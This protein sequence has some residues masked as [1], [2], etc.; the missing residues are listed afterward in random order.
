MRGA[1]S[2]ALKRNVSNELS[3]ANQDF[4]EFYVNGRRWRI[5]RPDPHALLLDWLRSPEV[6]LTG[7]KKGCGQGGCG[8]C[9]VMLSRWEPATG[10]VVHESINSCLRPLC[11]VDG[12]AVTTTEGTGNVATGLNPVQH[13]IAIDNGSQCGYCTPGW[14]MTMTAYLAANPGRKP[15]QLEIEQLFDGNLCRCTGYRPILYAMRHF[16]SDWTPADEQGSMTCIANPEAPIAPGIIAPEPPARRGGALEIAGE[17]STWYRPASLAELLELLGRLDPKATKL[18]NGNSSIGIYDRYDEHPAQ[19]VDISRLKELRQFK[20]SRTHLQFGA[21]GS[22]ADLLAFFAALPKEAGDNPAVAAMGY[23]AERTAGHIVRN[24]A[25]L[26]GNT[27][28]V[29]RHV[30][31]GVPFPS[32]LFTALCACSAEV[33]FALPGYAEHHR[34]PIHD[35]AAQWEEKPTLQRAVLVAYHVPLADKREYV[36]TYKVALREVNAHAIVNAGMRV[37]FDAAGKVEDCAVVL[38]GIGPIAFHAR[39]TQQAMVGQVWST[40]TL[41]AALKALRADLDAELK[42]WAKR[43]ADLPDEGFTDSYRRHLAESFLYKFFVEVAEATKAFPVPAPVAGAGQRYLRPL[44][45]GKQF[46][47][48]N[49]DPAPVGLPIVK[50]DAFLQ[51][52]GEAQY[53]HD[54]PLPPRGLEAALVLSDRAVGGFFFQLPDQ[55]GKPV[56]ADVLSDWLVGHY[57]GVERLVTAA[58]VP[59]KQNNRSAGVAD[60]VGGIDPLFAEQSV[61]WYGQPLGVLLAKTELQ[62]ID[63]A[64]FVRTRCVGYPHTPEPLLTIAAARASGSV[65]ADTPV[66]AYNHI[67]AIERPKSELGWKGSSKPVRLDGSECLVINGRQ[68]VGSQAHFY[69]ETQSIVAVP[70]EWGRMQLFPSTQSPD[71]VQTFAAD[72]LGTALGKIDVSVKRVGGG[73]GGKTTRPPFLAAPVALAAKVTGRPVRLAARREEDM[74]A[75]GR[76]HAYEGSY[77]LAVST[78]VGRADKGRILGADMT[79]WAN[80]GA[81]YDCSFVV[82]DCLQMRVD[83]AYMVPNWRTEGHVARTNLATSTAFRSM[84]LIQGVI[85]FEDAIAAAA[86]ALGMRAEDL[87][88]VNLYQP[89]DETVVGTV[90]DICY[91]RQVWKYLR[92]KADFDARAAA[93]D[94]FNQANR[95]RKRGIAMIPVQYGAGYN[96]AFLEQAG[97]LVEVYE[98]DA[99]LLIHQGGVELGQG[100]AVKVAQVAAQ[101][102][103]VPLELITIADTDL[104]VVPN[105]VSTGA[106]TGTGFNAEAVRTACIDLSDRLKAYVESLRK[107]NGDAWCTKNNI[108][109]WNYP[110]GWRAAPGGKSIWATIVGKAHFDRVNLSSQVRVAIPGGD[111]P[112][113][114]LQFSSPETAEQGVD[115]FTGYTFSA[116]CAEVE[117]DVLTGETTVLRA[118]LCYDI[119]DSLNPA[120]DIGQ[121]EG[122]FVQGLGYVLT[123]ELVTQQTGPRAGR[124][125]SNNTWGYKIP[126]TTSIPLEMNVGFFP[127][128]ELNLPRE[129][130]VVLGSKEVGEPPLVL[131]ATVFGAVKNAI[132]AARTDR[133]EAGWFE[134]DGPLTVQRVREACLVEAKDLLI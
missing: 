92:T 13:R 61:E 20:A 28:L 101:T 60:Q 23:L 132:L 83:S 57:P 69:M 43:M 100:L 47:P 88:E 39:R 82:S 120:I 117:I 73:Y 3:P 67:L 134:V 30:R 115:Q 64:H 74:E 95:W 72:V 54:I 10:K 36:Q 112:A 2:V 21:G 93:V 34:M 5:D 94:A 89:G 68:Q 90:L 37:R 66:P 44:S 86:H 9:T 33:E 16:A 49:A 24:V 97:A 76:R 52:S 70:G 56:D 102:L 129:I 84:G 35:F 58:D 126:A 106:S 130:D 27:M 109:Y 11:S 12:M 87:R 75:F 38:G 91:M 123:E 71:T 85:V 111:A 98:G 26:A 53:T 116:G 113:K 25:S 62:A 103:N 22:Y 31:R 119:G 81:T 55:P 4:I 46:V 51:A 79:F 50:Q 42:Q 17:G 48:P 118:D 19:L 65:L 80:G 77:S 127:R 121:V 114:N 59:A 63:V 124:L 105:P 6:G 104:G 131:A 15:S 45:R 108:D 110:E 128:A 41:A 99:S 96:A 133:G 40:A 125:N 122:A 1:R 32:D 7:A 18:V 8:L 14:V 107:A 29:A 78:G